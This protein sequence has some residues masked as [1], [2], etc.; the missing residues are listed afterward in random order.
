MDYRARSRYLEGSSPGDGGFNIMSRLV[1]IA[2][3]VTLAMLCVY[4][5]M[6]LPAVAGTPSTPGPI[7]GAGLPVIAV[8]VGAYWLYRRYHRDHA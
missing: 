7:V 6:V 4:F 3:A 8:A 1:D 5:S 2:G